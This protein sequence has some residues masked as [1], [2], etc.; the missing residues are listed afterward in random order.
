MQNRHLMA[1]SN[2]SCRPRNHLVATGK[3]FPNAWN[4][5]DGFRA[6]RGKDLPNWPEW[7]FLPLTAFYAIVSANSVNH[8]LPHDLVSDVA[9]LGA[10][11]TWRVTQGIY[12]FDPALYESV[13]DTPLNGT[14]PCD[15]F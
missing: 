8:H 7:C 6:D 4:Q 2:T 3:S 12:R 1:N 15:V 5:I 13:R 10:I 9:K 14:L 11:G